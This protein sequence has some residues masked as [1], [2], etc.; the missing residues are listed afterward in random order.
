M[1]LQ[2]CKELL[3]GRQFLL[4]ANG[5]EHIAPGHDTQLRT[6]RLEHPQV[7]VGRSVKEN[8]VG[9]VEKKMFFY[10]FTFLG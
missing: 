9:L 3:K 2:G 10:H 5:F 1:L 7:R 4:V 8:R 6:K